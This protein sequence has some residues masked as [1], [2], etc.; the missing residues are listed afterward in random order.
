MTFSLPK[1]FDERIAMLAGSATRIGGLTF[2][3]FAVAAVAQVVVGRL[4]D[5]HSIRTVFMFVAGFQAP[6]YA[7]MI[8]LTG[9]PALL[10]SLAF[11]LLLFGQIPINDTLVARITHSDWRSRVYGLKFVITF[12]VMAGTLPLVGWLYERW[13]FSALFASMAVVAAAMFIA[14]QMLPRDG[15]V[16]SP[17]PLT[18]GA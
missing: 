15:P 4:I 9:L 11:M 5:R 2:L 6:L 1:V 8:H 16:L 18:P 7:L 12:S 13:G 17:A 3:V 14:V 10:G